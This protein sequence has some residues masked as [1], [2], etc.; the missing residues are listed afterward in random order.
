MIK[1]GRQLEF[2]EAGCVVQVAFPDWRRHSVG[3]LGPTFL[4]GQLILLGFWSL[5]TEPKMQTRTKDSV[6]KQ[7]V[8]PCQTL[9][10]TSDRAIEV[11]WLGI[12]PGRARQTE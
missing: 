4:F 5:I 10:G 8:I 7:E 6:H 11:E 9:S 2:G 1:Q 3:L 12:Y